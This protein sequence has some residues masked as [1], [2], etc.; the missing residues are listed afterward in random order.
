LTLARAR[1]QGRV[2]EFA[3]DAFVK[4]SFHV[5]D[6]NLSIGSRLEAKLGSI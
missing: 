1:E 5:E 2:P 4:E 3:K 6:A